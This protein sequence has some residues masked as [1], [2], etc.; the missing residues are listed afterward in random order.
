MSTIT[1]EKSDIVKNNTLTPDE[2]KWHIKKNKEFLKVA[3]KHVDFSAKHFDN[4]EFAFFVFCAK[5]YVLYTVSHRS[6]NKILE[7]YSIAAGYHPEKKSILYKVI[8]EVYGNGF[9]FVSSRE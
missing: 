2:L 5:A 8:N 1:I 3:K 4:Q 7:K 9:T 6:T